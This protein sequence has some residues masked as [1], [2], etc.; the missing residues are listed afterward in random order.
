MLIDRPSAQRARRPVLV[1]LHWTLCCPP[2]T[3]SNWSEQDATFAS[4]VQ[5]AVLVSSVK[6][7]EALHFAVIW[8]IPLGGVASFV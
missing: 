1:Q 6:Q 7:C 5:H 2:A 3:D 8:T 4:L